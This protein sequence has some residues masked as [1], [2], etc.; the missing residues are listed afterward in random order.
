MP[1]V[2]DASFSKLTRAAL[3]LA[4]LT[5]LGAPL[6]GTTARAQKRAG[7]TTEED[8]APVYKEY[9]GVQIGMMAADVRQK[10]GNPKEKGDDQD[11]FVFSNEKETAQI[12][13]DKSHKVTTVSVDFQSGAPG[14]PL[15]KSVV[16]TDIPPEANGS[17]HLM[18]RYPKAGY[19]VS[20][21]RTAGNDPLI[22]VTIQK[23][24]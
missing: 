2:F 17:M 1:Q 4:T 5:L 16:G 22:S 15:P 11:F 8:A 6:S 14:I 19:W 18:V 21:S 23:I 7:Q 3:L 10:L 20:Y 9:R 13:Y 12:V 24:D